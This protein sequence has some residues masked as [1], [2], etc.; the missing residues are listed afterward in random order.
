MAI[1][2]DDEITPPR[3]ELRSQRAVVF[4]KRPRTVLFSKPPEVVPKLFSARGAGCCVCARSDLRI[5]PNPIIRKP[6]VLEIDSARSRLPRSADPIDVG[7]RTKMKE[8]PG[9]QVRCL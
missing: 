8:Q 2:W 7:L 6:F 3:S 1:W 9:A 4:V 5:P